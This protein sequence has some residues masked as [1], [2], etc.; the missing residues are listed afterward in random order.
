LPIFDLTMNY[1]P[2]LSLI[3]KGLTEITDQAEKLSELS[4]AV[5]ETMGFVQIE[6]HDDLIPSEQHTL[7]FQK[8]LFFADVAKLSPQL[9]CIGF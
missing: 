3:L 8:E 9:Y 7:Q 6:V 2:R 1:R 5:S 4:L